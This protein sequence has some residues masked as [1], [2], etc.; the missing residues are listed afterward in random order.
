MKLPPEERDVVKWMAEFAQWVTPSLG[1][2]IDT[3]KYKEEMDKAISVLDQLA[4]ATADF[5]SRAECS[6]DSIAAH[7]WARI[8]AAD[9]KDELQWLKEVPVVLCMVTGKSENNIKC[10]LPIFL[11]NEREIAQL[12][13]P[14]RT[15][16]RVYE[17]PNILSGTDF[18]KYVGLNQRN[19]ERGFPAL[20]AYLDLMLNRD[21]YVDQ[22]FS[23]GTAYV[24][25]KASGKERAL[26][27]PL[28]SFQ[29][30]GSVSATGGHGPETI[31]REYLVAW[32]LH[33][34]TDFNTQDVVV[35][36]I[37]EGKK[38][39]AY[40]FVFPNYLLGWPKRVFV[41]SQYYA[42]D[43]GSVSHKNVDQAAN[44]RVAVEACFSDPVFLEYMDGAGY[45]ASL[46][47][48]LRLLLSMGNTY[49]FFQIRSAP[50]RLRRV[51]QEIGYL[52]PLEVE[53]LV[54]FDPSEESV[55]NRLLN[56]GY[57]VEEIDRVLTMMVA[58]GQLF[59]EGDRFTAREDRREF[60]RQSILLD[61]LVI[62]GQPIE[63]RTEA[64]M[65]LVPGLGAY[66][67]MRISELIPA[68]RNHDPT[69]TIWSSDQRILDDLDWLCRKGFAM[70]K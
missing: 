1:E 52:T 36:P 40:D 42:G 8:E 45:C 57:R 35:T 16:E 28:I 67:G 68:I 18:M 17:V 61:A 54:V 65:A 62:D 31:L 14:S 7:L 25:L 64:G 30:R 69:N 22:L 11:R 5:Q 48:D 15:G 13:V 29:V 10:Q 47:G 51:F 44:S 32:G 3:A 49:S 38:T 21:E 46:N 9:P 66:H 50:V 12:G 4:E 59:Q 63:K 6:P 70:L 33:A 19:R 20:A 27:S 41:Q 43:S 34:G 55:K 58:T 2:I 56:D 37:Q 26:L 24:A 53:Q 23:I 39:R 60:I